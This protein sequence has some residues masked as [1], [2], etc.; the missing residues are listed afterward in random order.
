MIKLKVIKGYR[1]ALEVLSRKSV[2]IFTA[3]EEKAAR[4]II[5]KVRL[6]GDKA[7]REYTLEYDGV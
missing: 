3:D 2:S 4:D 6:E 1:K 7:L 5:D